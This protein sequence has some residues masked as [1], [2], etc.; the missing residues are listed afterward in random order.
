MKRFAL[1]LALILLE[2]PIYG[3][4]AASREIVFQSGDQR[5]L[6]MVTT[7]LAEEIAKPSTPPGILTAWVKL[8]GAEEPYLFVKLQDGYHCGNVN[9]EAWGFQKTKTG[10]RKVFSGSGYQWNVLA[11]SQEGHN[12]LSKVMHGGAFEQ[13][14]KIYHWAGG[15]YRQVSN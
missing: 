15:R 6:E 13:E 7:I 4:N 11:S 14:A 1:P 9:C 2:F 5:A 10:W 12:N 3:A 8:S